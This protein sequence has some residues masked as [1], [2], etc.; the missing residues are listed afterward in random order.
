MNV[1]PTTTSPYQRVIKSAVLQQVFI[2]V[3]VSMILDGGVVAEVCLFA[4]AAFWSGLALIT[5]R[6]RTPTKLDLILIQGGYIVL[7]VIAF[8]LTHWIWH[9]RSVI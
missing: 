8:F 5:S 6:R 2:L 4:A 9:L 3:L 1:Q 7:C